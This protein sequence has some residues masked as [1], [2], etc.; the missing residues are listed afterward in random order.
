MGRILNRGGVGE[1]MGRNGGVLKML[2]LIKSTA[3][4]TR[5]RLDH[6]QE[7]LWKRNPTTLKITPP[8]S[9]VQ[10]NQLGEFYW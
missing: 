10:T 6:V 4:D 1:Q 5:I 9:L 8:H 3:N 7:S 2:L